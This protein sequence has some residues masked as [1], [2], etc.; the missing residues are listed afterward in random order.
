MTTDFHASVLLYFEHL[1]YTLFS[2][3]KPEY[4]LVL[5]PTLQTLLI[6][7][8]TTECDWFYISFNA[9]WLALYTKAYVHMLLSCKTGAF[10][11]M[12]I[13]HTVGRSRHIILRTFPYCPVCLQVKEG[14]RLKEFLEDYDDDRDDPKY[15]R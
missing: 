6:T 12:I 15:Y 9:G 5:L 10:Q 11:L 13:S 2:F 3:N 8:S 14:K 1:V 4:S 7:N